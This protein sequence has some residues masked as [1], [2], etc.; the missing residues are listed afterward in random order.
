M[1]K[2][3][4]ILLLIILLSVIQNKINAQS[5]SKL[6]TAFIIFSKVINKYTSTVIY[7]K[8]LNKYIIGFSENLDKSTID[9]DKIKL[10]DTS[11]EK[12]NT[13]VIPFENN[14]FFY[15]N[16]TFIN[17]DKPKLIELDNKIYIVF[18]ADN[19]YRNNGNSFFQFNL[20]DFNLQNNYNIT[21][22]EGYPPI[23][24]Y[25]TLYSKNLDNNLL[26]KEFLLKYIKKSRLLYKKKKGDDNIDATQN[27]EAKFALINKDDLE[28]SGRGPSLFKTT[29][30]SKDILKY[31]GEY[32]EIE[33]S[34]FI[35][36]FNYK[37]GL[38]GYDKIN[39]KYYPIFL[40]NDKINKPEFIND[41][42]IRF[43]YS[44]GDAFRIYDLA[45]FTYEFH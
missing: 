9:I 15:Q 45:N 6:T 23:K 37:K 16:S 17:I 8:N 11:W 36:Y 14:H 26:Q 1:K 41:Y 22:K 32:N 43:N 2:I 19:K 12:D 5:F 20:V 13:I 28:G 7:D 38:I 18:S 30:Y 35:I 44:Y 31:F 3:K 39:K 42:V 33:N 21:L 40:A 4:N 27:F 25:D 34:Y 24:V 10:V 29:Y